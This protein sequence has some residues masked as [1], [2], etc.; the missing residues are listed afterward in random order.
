MTERMSAADLRAIAKRQQ[1]YGNVITTVDGI[2][3][4]SKRE[5]AYYSELKLREKAGEVY[6]VELQRPY[7][8]TI[9]G[10]LICTYIADFVFFDQT[11]MRTRCIDVKGMETDLFKIKRKLMKAIHNVEVECVK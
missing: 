2:K 7:A 5:A 1:K 4:H 9:D 8:L 11:V 3:F 10:R 6:E